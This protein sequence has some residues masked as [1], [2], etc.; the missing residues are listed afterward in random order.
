MSDTSKGIVY[1]KRDCERF[2][3]F[4]SYEV[5]RLIGLPDE[6]RYRMWKNYKRRYEICKQERRC[7]DLSKGRNSRLE[8]FED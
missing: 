7:N 2:R 4:R 1:R 6:E 5:Y 3:K 8:N